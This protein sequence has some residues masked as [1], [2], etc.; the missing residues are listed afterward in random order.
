MDCNVDHVPRY[1]GAFSAACRDL[2]M[3]MLNRDPLTRPQASEVLR[4]EW[5]KEDQPILDGL[6]HVNHIMC[7]NPRDNSNWERASSNG[8]EGGE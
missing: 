6:L 5:F 2:L 4:H 3:K 8:N 1:M 7:L